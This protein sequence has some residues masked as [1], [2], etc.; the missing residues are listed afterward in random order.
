MLSVIRELVSRG[1]KFQVRLAGDGPL[2][3]KAQEQVIKD[4]LTSVV[5]FLGPLDNVETCQEIARANIYMQLSADQEVE[6]PGGSYIHSEGMGRSILE[7]LTA[8]IFV[9]AGRSGALPEIVKEDLGLLVELNHAKQ[10]ADQIEPILQS[11]PNRKPFSE[12]YSWKNIFKSYEEQWGE[13][14]ENIACHRK[15]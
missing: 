14:G 5:T 4:Q 10:I 2:L 3:K 12:H 6:V 15:V 7:A 11:L 8:G 9:I 13:L 1:Y